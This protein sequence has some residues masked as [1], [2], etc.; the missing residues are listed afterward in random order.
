MKV[1]IQRS[2]EAKVSVDGKTVGQIDI[3]KNYNIN[4]I[5]IKKDGDIN[6]IVSPENV[7]TSDMSMMVVGDYKD[8]QRLYKK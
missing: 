2:K 1:V 6:L 3:R 4:L 5:A 7:L 8:V